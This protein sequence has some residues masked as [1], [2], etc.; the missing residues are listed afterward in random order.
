MMN[1]KLKIPF[2]E[3]CP[4][5]GADILNIT[6]PKESDGLPA[7]A[8]GIQYE[9]LTYIKESESISISKDCQIKVLNKRIAELEV[10]QDANS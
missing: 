7:K 6:I 8:T 4:K 10:K 1:P 5:C 9:C 3:Q 2:P